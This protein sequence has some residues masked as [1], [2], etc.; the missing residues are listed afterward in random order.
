MVQG[1][2]DNFG[3][4]LGSI[5]GRRRSI[6]KRNR[7]KI[8]AASL[9]MDLFKGAGQQ[10]QQGV[11]DSVNTLNDKWGDI[12]D[13]QNDLW[14]DWT[15]E[16]RKRLDEYNRRGN[17]YLN[18]RA[19]NE[20]K[21]TDAAIEEGI[22]WENR[23]D[24]T[25]SKEAREALMTSFNAERERALAE[26]NILKTDPRAQFETKTGFNEKA[27]NA[28]L[29]EYNL[30]TKDPTQKGVVRYAFNRAFRTE[31]DKEGNLVSTNAEKI[32]LEDA[33]N[34]AVAARNNQDADIKTATKSLDDLYTG[35]VG[36]KVNT[37]EDLIKLQNK[38]VILA[39][40]GFKQ[41][42]IITQKNKDKDIW[43]DKDPEKPG[44]YKEGISKNFKEAN[45]IVD[46]TNKQKGPQEGTDPTTGKP[47]KKNT[48]PI[49]R[50]NLLKN[51]LADLK[52][53]NSEG[54]IDPLTTEKFFNKLAITELALN[55]SLLA[56]GKDALTGAPLIVAALE[57][58]SNEGRFSKLVGEAED[59][60]WKRDRVIW[61]QNDIL[62]TLPTNDGYNL[63]NNTVQTL[64]AV[65]MNQGLGGANPDEFI[66]DDTDEDGV[67]KYNRNKIIT[68]ANSTSGIDEDT[69]KPIPKNAIFAN[70]SKE[71]QDF[72]IARFL[73]SYPEH[74]KDIINIFSNSEYRKIQKEEKPQKRKQVIIDTSSQKEPTVTTRGFEYTKAE[75]N[76]EDLEAIKKQIKAPFVR[77]KIESLAKAI[78]TGKYGA[79]GSLLAKQTGEPYRTLTEEERK[80]AAQ[81]II[82]EL[83]K[84]IG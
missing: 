36:K 46:V 49:E 5:L 83:L 39:R 40:Q 79:V 67:K 26:I 43:F 20:M 56:S 1:M 29:A 7:R 52:V 75:V 72:E 70:M 71:G 13:S 3:K 6:Q 9:F 47:Y 11:V 50:V 31:R 35:V 74:E 28:Y 44:Q 27:K 64:D 61:D 17:K 2:G 38:A 15:D 22:T 62:V 16:G 59:R 14:K 63:V 24:P 81:A 34:R 73:S 82:D 48:Y 68:Y 19:A 4:A 51:N 23:N 25:V 41:E 78:T 66:P 12:T 30:I 53:Q 76:E 69:G 80:I 42:E 21:Y 77:T 84:D 54:E 55:Q 10:L 58:W 18:E 37:K 33:L 8:L 57:L 65:G 32:E 60:P 45:I